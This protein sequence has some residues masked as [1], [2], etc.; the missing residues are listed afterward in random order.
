MS[1]FALE[2]V[3]LSRVWEG[4]SA[5]VENFE[6]RYLRSPNGNDTTRLLA[7][8]EERSFPSMLGSIDCIHWKWNNCPTT[9]HNLYSDHVRV[10]TI[11]LEVVASKYL[12]GF[13]ILIL[14]YL[15]DTMILMFFND[16]HYLQSYVKVKHPKLFFQSMVMITKW[17]N[18]LPMHIS[19]LVNICED[20]RTTTEE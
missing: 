3:Q 18:T 15:D 8:A 7:I 12:Y 16:L 17:D 9:W 20:H 11:I 4:L 13:G 10:P 5:V 2:K 6:A 1:V 19:I 14:V